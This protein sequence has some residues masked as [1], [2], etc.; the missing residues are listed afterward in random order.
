MWQHQASDWKSYASQQ[1]RYKHGQVALLH[2]A[3]CLSLS[4]FA[5][6]TDTL[7]NADPR[8]SSKAVKP[9]ERR[10]PVKCRF[11]VFRK[12]VAFTLN[13]PGNTLLAYATIILS[14]KAER[15]A[16]RPLCSVAY[17]MGPSLSHERAISN[18]CPDAFVDTL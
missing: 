1:Q 14:S 13:K 4:P 7:L 2:P 10:G 15:A 8:I 18:P 5:M 11:L 6:G 9:F 12:G 3:L 17:G 16:S